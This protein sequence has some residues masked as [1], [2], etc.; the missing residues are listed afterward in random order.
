MTA[1]LGAIDLLQWQSLGPASLLADRSE[2]SSL[3]RLAGLS[4]EA[5]VSEAISKVAQERAPEVEPEAAGAPA[6]ASSGLP[7]VNVPADL[8]V[9]ETTAISREADRA[10]I[11]PKLLVAIRRT[12]NGGPGREF[13]VLSVAAPGVDAQ[14]RVAANTVRST[15]Q[16]FERGGE[17][18]VDP[19]TGRYTDA[20]LRYLSARY[21]PIGAANDPTGLNRHHAANL[22]ALYQKVSGRAGEI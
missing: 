17:V 21:A 10:G 19:A 15:I 13:G 4:F 12:E 18:A 8:P 1:P 22:I 5:A 20:F 16:R 14:A 11:D 2:A 9:Q 7:L 6:A 3:V